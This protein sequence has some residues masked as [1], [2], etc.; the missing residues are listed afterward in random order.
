MRERI[1]TEKLTV[2]VEVGDP[3]RKIGPQ[4]VEVR[5]HR[6]LRRM[7][8]LTFMGAPEN[9]LEAELELILRAYVLLRRQ[10]RGTVH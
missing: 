10:R 9:I 3:E 8:D 4:A 1:E 2:E 7:S 6:R 5:L